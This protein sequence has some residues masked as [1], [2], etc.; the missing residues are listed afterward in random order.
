VK[1][2]WIASENKPESY[3]KGFNVAGRPLNVV[4]TIDRKNSRSRAF[5]KAYCGA[6]RLAKLCPLL[7]S[8]CHHKTQTTN[9]IKTHL[10]AFLLRIGVGLGFARC[11][12][13]WEVNR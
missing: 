5:L 2:L 10:L 11:F 4:L 7:G 8:P 12:K 3:I 1:L 9:V 6:C 13:S